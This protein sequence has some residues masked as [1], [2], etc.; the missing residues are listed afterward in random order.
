MRRRNEVQTENEIGAELKVDQLQKR[1]VY[2]LQ[3]AGRPATTM[4]CSDVNLKDSLVLFWAGSIFTT[5]IL[6]VQLDGTMQDDS[7]AKIAV[8]E[9]LGEV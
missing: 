2:V 9:Y 1:K 5:L 4:W 7:G 3:K 6:F 8:H